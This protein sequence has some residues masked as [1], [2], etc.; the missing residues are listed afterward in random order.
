M[1]ISLP[2]VRFLCRVWDGVSEVVGRQRDAMASC[3]PGRNVSDENEVHLMI[4]VSCILYLLLVNQIF[5]KGDEI[6]RLLNK[7]LNLFL[8]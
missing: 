3:S 6:R 1:S 8:R 7:W 5:D 2:V 4:G